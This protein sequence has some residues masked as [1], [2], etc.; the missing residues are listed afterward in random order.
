MT[1]LQQCTDRRS[2]NACARAHTLQYHVTTRVPRL[3]SA[4]ERTQQALSLGKEGFRKT[5]ARRGYTTAVFLVRLC[6]YW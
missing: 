1:K 4:Q 2:A 3:G 5:A 6:S